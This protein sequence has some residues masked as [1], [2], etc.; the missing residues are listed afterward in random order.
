MNTTEEILR[1]YGFEG[2][3]VFGQ[4]VAQEDGTVA[5]VEEGDREPFG[6]GG[7]SD[8]QTLLQTDPQFSST[9]TDV[10]TQL[11]A[12]GQTD[13][14]GAK[15]ALSDA[16]SQL[17]SQSFGGLGTVEALDAAKSY[18]LT[19]ETI[20]GAVDTVQGL[21]QT[22]EHGTPLQVVQAFT[23]TMVGLGIA[24]GA[25][26]AGVGAA[27]VGVVQTLLQILQSNHFFGEPPPAAGTLC[28]APLD[29]KPDFTIGCLAVWAD[30]GT[31]VNLA[32]DSAA[33]RPFPSPSDPQDAAWFERDKNY[34]PG[35]WRGAFFGVRAPG[36]DQSY[37]AIG[38]NPAGAGVRPIDNAFD[39]ADIE[40][41]AADTTFP[42]PDFAKAWI[43][44]WKAN[45][46]YL[47][48][49]LKAQEDWVVLVHLLQLWNRAHSA[50]ST[51]FLNKDGPTYLQGLAKIASTSKLKKDD[52]LVSLDSQGNVNGL[53]VHSGPL[54]Q[55]TRVITLRLPHGTHPQAPPAPAA[56][57]S[58]APAVVGLAAVGLG[59]VAWYFLGKPLTWAALKRGWHEVVREFGR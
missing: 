27:I 5:Y 1:G 31:S 10:Q 49:G 53:V 59:G 58:A 26:T 52:P 29:L 55:P 40:A 17:I 51:L 21:V 50:S 57:S 19:G 4:E 25:V 23:G 38:I 28:G 22:I 54:K 18:V 35:E 11:M 2:A 14:T 56:T 37:G 32:P 41:L 45:A 3:P 13:L 20:A 48:N 16:Y 9:W 12:E 7:I 44:A 39:Y 6:L 15:I 42:L 47:L 24:T 34:G 36:K 43:T 8:F 30:A 46:A 33:W